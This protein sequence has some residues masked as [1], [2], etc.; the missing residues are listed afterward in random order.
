MKITKAFEMTTT[1]VWAAGLTMLVS[2]SSVRADEFEEE[3]SEIQ[4]E[5]IGKVQTVPVF[6]RDRSCLMIGIFCLKSVSA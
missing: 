3:E 4:M 1:A 6:N 5:V 2:A